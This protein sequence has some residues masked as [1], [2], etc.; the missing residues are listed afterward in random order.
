[1]VDKV[2]IIAKRF[3]FVGEVQ[4]VGFRWTAI[5]SQK[6]LGVHGYVKNLASGEVELV[7]EGERE[8]ID[9]LLSSLR[10]KFPNNIKDVKEYDEKV[11]N[12]KD[13]NIE[14]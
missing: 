12:Y 5:R 7:V 13:F 9:T 11:Q 2:K 3:I 6:G 4:G 8:G 10:Q 1:M 14:V